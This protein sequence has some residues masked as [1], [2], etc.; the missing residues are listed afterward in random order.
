MSDSKNMIELQNET[1]K[2]DTETFKRAI[3]NMIATNDSA[4]T[5]DINVMDAHM[6]VPI[7]M[8]K[9]NALL[10]LVRQFKNPFCQI[11]IL[12]WMVSIVELL[13]IM[14]HI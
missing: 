9:F 6:R 12:L 1:H 13:F 8:K 2:V 10:I 3:T 4:Y 5:K 11:I 7:P 14:P